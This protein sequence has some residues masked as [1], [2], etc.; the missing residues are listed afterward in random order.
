MWQSLREQIA[1]NNNNNNNNKNSGSG[2]APTPQAP[3]SS[4][5]S[6][7]QGCDRV[8]H[9]QHPT[10]KESLRAVVPLLQDHDVAVLDDI[11]IASDL[12][13]EV[14]PKLHCKVDEDEEPEEEYDDTEESETYNK[15]NNSS[16][17]TSNTDNHNNSN[18]NNDNDNNSSSLRSMLHV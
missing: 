5:P 13:G 17:N 18:D 7:A 2:Q 6:V 8:D 14:S 3:P 1:L 4:V 15:Y 9:H 12:V 10:H 11:T 16:N